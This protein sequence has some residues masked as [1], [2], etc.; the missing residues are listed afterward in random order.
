MVM[1]ARIASPLV[2]TCG[3][4]LFKRKRGDGTNVVECFNP[5]CA[6]IGKE[7]LAPTVQL[8]EIQAEASHG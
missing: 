2:C 7:F 3:S 5:L 8:E 6:L 1:M 4:P